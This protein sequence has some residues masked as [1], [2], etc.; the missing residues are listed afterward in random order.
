MSTAAILLLTKEVAGLS[1]IAAGPVR[2][3]ACARPRRR[4]WEALARIQRSLRPLSGVQIAKGWQHDQA[5]EASD[6]CSDLLELVQRL[7]DHDRESGESHWAATDYAALLDEVQ[8]QLAAA[9]QLLGED[10]AGGE[11]AAPTAPL[12]KLFAKFDSIVSEASALSPSGDADTEPSATPKE[13]V[14]K[15]VRLSIEELQDE[16]PHC[17]WAVNGTCNEGCTVGGCKEHAHLAVEAW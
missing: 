6:C 14:R 2:A 1:D 3:A 5:R 10:D 13:V 12:M 7:Q 9:R 8:L 17:E 16:Y 4:C 11:L 15:P